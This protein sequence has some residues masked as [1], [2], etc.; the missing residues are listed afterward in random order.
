M[1]RAYVQ[2]LLIPSLIVPLYTQLGTKVHR[3]RD[4]QKKYALVTHT[5][6]QSFS[7]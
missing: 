7:V 2:R 3:T 5:E 6:I 1:L 4:L